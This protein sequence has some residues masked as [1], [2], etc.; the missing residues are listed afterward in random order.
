[1]NFPRMRAVILLVTSG[2]SA[3]A[4]SP[5]NPPD[6]SEVVVEL[7][8][9]RLALVHIPSG[10]FVMGSNATVKD[11]HIN[12]E[13]GKGRPAHQ[14]TISRDYWMG[15]YPVTQGQWQAVMGN[16]PSFFKNAGNDAPV[17][18][19]SWN[20]A[21]QF[22]KRL[23]GMQNEW[24]FRLPTEAE[25]EHACRAWTTTDTYAGN[26]EIRGKSN[27]PTL[28]AIAW[29]AG[30]SGV[31]YEGGVDSSS[32]KEKQY[33]HTRAGTHPVGQKKP[34]SFGLFDM[35]G[36]VWQFCQD[37]YMDYSDA[38]VTDPRGPSNG[39]FRVSRGGSFATSA[40]FTR[41]THRGLAIQD[42]RY[43]FDGFR[44]C[45]DARRQS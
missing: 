6:H 37:W 21:Q 24:I 43:Y 38:A 41:S 8:G 14:V 22:M 11:R 4:P 40:A 44:V 27:S 12:A 13:L 42:A 39:R 34:N 20:D 18:Q 5:G 10:R 33:P 26:L 1:M 36:N 17:E 31:S 9:V 30:N 23:N 29:Y 3:Q 2:L 45:A 7:E 28:D 35:Q 25:W 19:V 32:W 16:N 15:K